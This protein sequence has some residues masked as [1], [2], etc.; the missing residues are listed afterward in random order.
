M[1]AAT[2]VIAALGALVV[3]IAYP[4]S[5][6]WPSV[7]P[8]ALVALLGTIGL[9]AAL[10]FRRLNKRGQ[11]LLI[12]PALLLFLALAL[13][14]FVSTAAALVVALPA[15]AAAFYSYA[16]LARPRY[17]QGFIPRRLA[18]EADLVRRLVR[19]G[20]ARLLLDEGGLRV[21]SDGGRTRVEGRPRVESDEGG[22][23]GDEGDEYLPLE[24]LQRAELRSHP[25]QTIFTLVDRFGDEAVKMEV[26]VAERAQTEQFMAL[27]EGRIRAVGAAQESLP[28]LLV[29]SGHSRQAWLESLLEH[30]K[31]HR[32]Y[33]GDELSDDDL[34]AVAANP[35]NPAESRAGAVYVLAGRQGTRAALGALR[36]REVLTA[37]SPLSF[38]RLIEDLA[39]SKEP[40]LRVA[41]DSHGGECEG[42]L[43][44]AAH[45]AEREKEISE[46][47]VGVAEAE[48]VPDSRR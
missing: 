22:L 24:T 44:D 25:G 4:L 27:L 46:A 16:V 5:K 38:T 19:C 34:I 30:G 48:A 39:S 47:E 45:D 12:L 11:L 31:Q 2:A 43:A 13:A 17:A 28:K 42:G 7:G 6:V 18:Q 9:L 26:P 35:N 23:R 20:S 37:K 41:V 33:R 40:T 21:E 15:A 1:S 36:E 32:A 3:M 29:R 8:V 10:E 14:Q